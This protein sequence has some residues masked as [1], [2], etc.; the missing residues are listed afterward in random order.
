MNIFVGNLAWEV[1]D[2]DLRQ[3]FES[4]GTVTTASVIRDRDSGKSRGFGFVEMPENEEAVKAINEL[5]GKDLK[6]RAL[7]VN[8]A[9]A[10]SEGSQNRFRR[11]RERF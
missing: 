10:K 6:G 5:N 7:R 2:S 1:T 4:F 3:A 9:R 11:N 8:E